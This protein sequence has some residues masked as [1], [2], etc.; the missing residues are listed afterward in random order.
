VLK[1]AAHRGFEATFLTFF[2]SVG[3]DDAAACGTAIR[4]IQ[5]IVVEDVTQSDVFAGQP[6]LNVLLDAGSGPCNPRP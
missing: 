1:I 5:R 6:I 2:A 4:S 3:T